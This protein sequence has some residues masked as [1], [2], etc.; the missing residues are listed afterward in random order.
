[1]HIGLSQEREDAY[2][3]KMRRYSGNAVDFAEDAAHLN[4]EIRFVAASMSSMFSEDSSCSSR[5]LV[6]FSLSPAS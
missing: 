4:T 1:M 6:I 5:K 2:L 3:L